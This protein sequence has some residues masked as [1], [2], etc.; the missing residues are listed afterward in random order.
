MDW[1]ESRHESRPSRE[2]MNQKEAAAAAKKNGRERSRA[3]RRSKFEQNRNEL[4]KTGSR[5]QHHSLVG[6][7][8]MD[9]CMTTAAAYWAKGGLYSLSHPTWMSKC[10]WESRIVIVEPILEPSPPPTV[11]LSTVGTHTNALAPT[12]AIYKDPPACAWKGESRRFSPWSH[13]TKP[14]SQGEWR[15]EGKDGKEMGKKFQVQDSLDTFSLAN[16]FPP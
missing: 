5:L 11:P 6:W 12:L 14:D 3:R 10:V 9:G 7:R 8:G 13:Q 1:G 15:V 2:F 16:F 4:V